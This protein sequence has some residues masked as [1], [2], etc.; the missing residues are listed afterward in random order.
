MIHEYNPGE[1]KQHSICNQRSPRSHIS[2]VVRFFCSG[3]GTS[4]P[5]HDSKIF[6][7]LARRQTSLTFLA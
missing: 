6:C 4:K 1:G 7:S 2:Y 3:T 5:R